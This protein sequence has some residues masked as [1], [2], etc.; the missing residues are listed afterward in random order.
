MSD[1]DVQGQRNDSRGWS[2][3]LLFDAGFRRIPRSN[4][5]E[6][7]GGVSVLS[8]GVSAG[9]HGMFLVD[10]R[11]ANLDKIADKARASLLLRIVPTGFALIPFRDIEPHLNPTT[12]GY[13]PKSG[14]LYRFKTE[15]D[16]TGGTVTLR[17]TRDPNVAVSVGLLDRNGAAEALARLV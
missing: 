8:P 15:V 7:S 17:S 16:A 11:Q 1:F 4:L 10:V 3:D 6:S 12:E 9:E 5:F 13:G 2:V 14:V